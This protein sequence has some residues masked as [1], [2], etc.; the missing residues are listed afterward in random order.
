MDMG[1][2]VVST[3]KSK[4]NAK[5]FVDRCMVCQELAEDVHHIK[6]QCCANI[7]NII[8]G[9]IQKDIKSNLV[10]LCKECHDKVHNKGIEINGYIQ[11]S[12]GIELDFKYLTG[13]ELKA[14]VKNRKKYSDSDLKIIGE[15]SRQL[16][17]KMV[18]NILEK[19][20]NIKISYGTLNKI[21]MGNY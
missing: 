4:Y 3:K 20:H 14:K 7:N 17:K 10:P 11:T 8:D 1:N 2:N 6:F 19:E 12:D 18:C 15:M 16:S 13:E 5:V 9:H 21:W